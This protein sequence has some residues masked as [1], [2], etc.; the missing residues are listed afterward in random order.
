MN[1]LGHQTRA[2]VASNPN[3]ARKSSKY[4]LI[5]QIIRQDLLQNSALFR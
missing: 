1:L 3:L 2:R 4:F 5:D